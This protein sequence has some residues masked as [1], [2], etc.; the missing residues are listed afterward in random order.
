M[1]RKIHWIAAS[2][3]LKRGST[4]DCFAA[5]RLTVVQEFIDTRT[6]DVNRSVPI[7][8]CLSFTYAG[9]GSGRNAVTAGVD[10]VVVVARA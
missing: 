2:P 7:S 1:S 10:F 5:V 6:T 3:D 8:G 9:G 4:R